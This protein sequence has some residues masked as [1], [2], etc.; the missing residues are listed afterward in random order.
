MHA[1]HGILL[2]TLLAV[3]AAACGCGA[4][5]QSDT[6]AASSSSRGMPGMFPSDAL[7][8]EG[9]GDLVLVEGDHGILLT[10]AEYN[11]RAADEPLMADVDTTTARRMLLDRLV[12]YKV[13]AVEAKLRG[14]KASEA[15]TTSEEERE[16]ARRILQESI[17]Q[18]AAIG[19]EQARAFV[20]DHPERF[21]PTQA[22]QLHDPGFLMH[23][24]YMLQNDR[25]REKLIAWQQRERVTVHLERFD[26]LQLDAGSSGSPTSAKE[27]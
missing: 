27:L 23:V 11:G 25:L 21:T 22:R 9:P 17:T 12:D 19:D 18:A 7:R 2:P 26:A 5:E 24:K 8:L 3:A 15:S 13:A 16:L 1:R 6:S 14:L 4:R 20:R 10:L